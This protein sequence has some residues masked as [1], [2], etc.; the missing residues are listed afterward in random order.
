MKAEN[1]FISQFQCYLYFMG[2]LVYSVLPFATS[3]RGSGDKICSKT[4]PHSVDIS[5]MRGM[6]E[7]FIVLWCSGPAVCF[8]VVCNCRYYCIAVNLC[9][10]LCC[11]NTW[12]FL[13]SLVFLGDK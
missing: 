12:P 4:Y 7:P 11:D 2:I 10:C 5:V 9:F 13:K 8:S 3:L 6:R 1:I